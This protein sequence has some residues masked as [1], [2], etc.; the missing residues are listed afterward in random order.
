MTR[1]GV[2]HLGTWIGITCQNICQSICS[3]VTRQQ[4][5]DDS[6]GKRF[7]IV[8]QARSAFIQYQDN[9]FTGSSQCLNEFT[10]AGRDGQVGKITRRFAIRVFTDAGDDDVNVLCS[11][12]GFFN[13]RFVF[14]GIS[15]FR[16][17]SYAL[18]K[19]DVFSTELVAQGFV[20]GIVL[21][22]KS[23]CQMSLP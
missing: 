21:S 20:D 23:V 17:V 15:T 4:Y 1:V 22:G 18:F 11:S 3:I 9:R 19:S 16:L 5:V 2:R 13:F 12:Y 7:Q 8:Y 6:A 10:L 14:F